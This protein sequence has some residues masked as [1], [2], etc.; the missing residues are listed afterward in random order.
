ME[1]NPIRSIG[2][3]DQVSRPVSRLTFSSRVSTAMSA[4]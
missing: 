3:V 2:H 4:V 1:R